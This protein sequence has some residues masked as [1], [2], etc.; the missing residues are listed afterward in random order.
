MT[1][2]EQRELYYSLALEGEDKYCFVF[3]PEG[4]PFAAATRINISENIPTIEMAYEIA[5]RLF[6]ESA[7][8]PRIYHVAAFYAPAGTQEGF[9]TF[10]SYAPFLGKD[11]LRKKHEL[12]RI[13]YD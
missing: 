3:V 10:Y 2:K 7:I 12:R 5:K 8:I 1:K 6:T 11:A 4:V 13:L 9:E